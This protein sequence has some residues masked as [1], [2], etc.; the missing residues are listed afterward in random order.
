MNRLLRICANGAVMILGVSL[1]MG[2]MMMMNRY[3]Q[4]PQ[5]A[6][7]PATTV[8]EVQAPKPKPKKRRARPK[9][10]QAKPR[11]AKAKT[12]PPN[13]STGLSSVS[14]SRVSGLGGTAMGNGTSLLGQSESGNLLMTSDTVDQ[15]PR[16]TR[17]ISP[18]YPAH[19]RKKG[20]TGY[21]SFSLVIGTDGQIVRSKITD[22][23][24]A[25]VFESAA[26]DAIQRWTF[27]PGMYQGQTQ[28]VVVEQTIRFNLSRGA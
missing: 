22:A 3:T 6:E 21:V 5:K 14:L 17:R 1:V 28:T 26:R 25:G 19:A 13:L 7:K 4:P 10:Q 24:P 2:L 23:K 20:I 11:T 15:P 27:Q 12:P 16:A 8:V 9:P 18:S